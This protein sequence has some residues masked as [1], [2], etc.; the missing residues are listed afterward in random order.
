MQTTA[1]VAVVV[2][3]VFAAAHSADVALHILLEMM[4]VVGTVPGGVDLALGHLPRARDHE[5]SNVLVETDRVGVR[6][7]GI[8]PA[9]SSTLAAAM[10]PA[11]MT[12][13]VG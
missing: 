13:G 12:E 8:G 10:G 4:G 5:A 11:L 1:D 7:G 2:V 9:T 3:A 6:S